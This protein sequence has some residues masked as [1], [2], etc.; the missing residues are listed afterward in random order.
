MTIQ[1]LPTVIKKRTAISADNPDPIEINIKNPI[2]KLQIVY[3]NT[4]GATG[5]PTG[6]PIRCLSGISLDDGSTNCF[7]LDG[8]ETQAVDF[9][10]NQKVPANKILYANGMNSEMVANIN[11]GRFLWD[12]YAW[13]PRKYDNPELTLS[14]DID[15][16]GITSSAGFYTVLAQVF[17]KPFNPPGYLYHQKVKDITLANT[18]TDYTKLPTDHPIRKLLIRAQRYGTG[19][20]YQIDTVD[21]KQEG[22]EKKIIDSLTMFQLLRLLGS[23][24]PPYRET[25]IG[26]GTTT[27]QEFYNTPTY[28]PMFQGA[29]AWRKASATGNVSCY[30]GDGGRFYEIQEGAGPNFSVGIEGHAPHGVVD[31]PFGDQLNPLEWY[32]IPKDGNC[33]LAIKG[34]SSVGTNQTAEVLLQQLKRYDLGQK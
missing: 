14:I 28:W 22:P 19:P 18:S 29:C 12:Q 9:Y 16:G 34:G 7:S 4:N 21:L 30:E 17:D 3:E 2:S 26:N 5:I 23:E 27:A 1:Y 6:H 31:I 20:E 8:A 10:H 33:E 24:Y 32:Q 13:D 25:I 11:F 15:A